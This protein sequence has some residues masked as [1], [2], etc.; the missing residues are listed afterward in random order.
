MAQSRGDLMVP[1]TSTGATRGR[2]AAAAAALLA[3]HVGGEA[4]A[5]AEQD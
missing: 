3:L 4:A 1:A 2:A 5:A